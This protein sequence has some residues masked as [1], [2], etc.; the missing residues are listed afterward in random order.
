MDVSTSQPHDGT[1]RLGPYPRMVDTGWSKNGLHW[2][3]DVTFGED[4][5]RVRTGDDPGEVE[6]RGLGDHRDDSRRSSSPTSP[7]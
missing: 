6:A 1:P 5:S 3:R 2:V 4:A 7:R